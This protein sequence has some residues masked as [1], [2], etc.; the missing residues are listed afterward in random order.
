[1]GLPRTTSAQLR[2]RGLEALAKALGPIGMARFLLQFE[3]GSGDYA[4][5]REGWLK[6]LTVHDVAEEIKGGRKKRSL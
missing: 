1:M 4:R 6:G 5:D 3:P 2:E